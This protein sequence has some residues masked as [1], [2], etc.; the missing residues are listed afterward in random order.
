VKPAIF[1]FT[2]PKMNRH[3]ASEIG[4][5][6]N[7]RI[8]AED[9]QPTEDIVKLA[10]EITPFFLHHNAEADAVDLLL[11]L[12]CI[13]KIVP[14]IDENTFA[15]V[16][17]YMVSCVP[18]LPYP[19][20]EAVLKAAHSIYRRVNRIPEAMIL[21]M[22]LDDHAL[23][24]EDF[25]AC[26]DPMLR[27]QLAFMLARQSICLESDNE[28]EQEI[29]FN[30]KLS[31]H[32]HTLGQ[33]LGVM[34][35]KTPEDIYKTHLETRSS[36]SIDSAKQNLASSL[37]NGFINA[38]FGKDKLLLVDDN[39][40]I[41]RNKDNAMLSAT[42]SL[43]LLLLWD[44]ENG[45]S[46][47]DKY[48]YNNEEFI[49]AGALLAIGMITAHVRNESDP[50]MA[51]LSEHLHEGPLSVR[52]SAISGLGM[53]YSGSGRREVAEMLIPLVVDGEEVSCHAALALGMILVGSCDGDLTSSILQILMESP[54]VNS[55]SK[56]M[57]LGL[58]LLYLG[59]QEACEATMETLKAIETPIS[60][61]FQVLVEVCAYAGT[62]NVLKV[63]SMTRMCGDHLS[64][65]DEWQG[66][67]ILG[68]A[69]I[70][71]GEDI[72]AEMALRTFNHFM[73]YGEPV[74]RRAVPLAIAL[75]CA[76]NP[77]V[78]VLD[79]LSKYSHDHDQEVAINA[80]FAMGMV[81][82]GTNNAR[83]AQMLR[84]LASYYNKDPNCLFMVRFAQGLI[85]MGK[86]TLSLNPQHTNR[87]LMSRVGIAGLITVLVAMT[88]SKNLILGNSHWMLYHLVNAIYP[89]FL[90]TLDEDLKPKS[91][92][93]R[94]G[95]AVDVVG[96]AGRPK[97][98]TGFQTHN[99]PV[100]M[101]YGERAELA[102]DECK[103]LTFAI[104]C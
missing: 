35:P 103:L 39:Q 74:I 60:K 28:Q 79:T 7:A 37:V 41:Y 72:G 14:L 38:G 99:T 81:G 8:I 70:G 95:Q 44:V 62:G 101:A 33:E 40:W 64:E 5:E 86:G 17:L 23:I 71:M 11:E 31:E 85:H 73:H 52:L 12:E 92:S 24:A 47:I 61:Q 94:V 3:L 27:K 78:H 69:M 42:A 59:K 80:I 83:L 93:V 104:L 29:L 67:A 90:I 34:D 43:G 45:L 30:T 26:T 13:D 2:V 87:N 32:F 48:L 10:I 77:V 65:N 66:F 89:R 49:K 57:A 18:Y 22:R 75:I 4:E 84:Q 58:A 98:I 56:F 9:P 102:T 50:A 53:A 88:D 21:A 46:Q 54:V 68:I 25:K 1:V 36:Y 76:S 6:Y 15:R 51:L 91:V 19:E 63:Q 20:D 96:Q 97:T 55:K 16:G 82:A 100:L